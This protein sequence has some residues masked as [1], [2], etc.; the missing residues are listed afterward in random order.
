[1]PYCDSIT[2]A[3]RRS[4]GANCSASSCSRAAESV[5]AKVCLDPDSRLLVALFLAMAW[6]PPVPRPYSQAA[7][8]SATLLL[9]HGQ[10]LNGVDRGARPERHVDSRVENTAAAARA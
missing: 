7:T 4:A 9:E 8:V 2:C 10:D 3:W 6:L 5:C 1:M